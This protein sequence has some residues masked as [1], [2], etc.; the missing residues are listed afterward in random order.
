MNIFVD[1]ECYWVDFEIL[2]R[3]VN[4]K[5]VGDSSDCKRV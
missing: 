2:L 5:E 1:F 3:W 4:G